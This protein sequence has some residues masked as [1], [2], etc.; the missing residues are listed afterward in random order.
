M[1]VFRGRLKAFQAFLSLTH[2]TSTFVVPCAV[3][4]VIF[5]HLNRSF[6]LTYL[7]NLGVRPHNHAISVVCNYAS[8]KCGVSGSIM[9]SGCSWVDESVCP[10]RTLLTQY[11]EICRIY[12]HQTC[13]LGVLLDKD[14][15]FDVWGLRSSSSRS[16]LV[17]RA[18][19][20]TFGLVDEMSWKLVD[21][22]SPNFGFWCT[23][24]QRRTTLDFEGHGVRVKV[25]ARSDVKKSGLSPYLLNRLNYHSHIEV[26]VKVR[27]RV[28]VR[29]K[30]TVSGVAKGDM[31]ACPPVVAG[32]LRPQTATGAL[33]LDP[34][35][36]AIPRPLLLSPVANSW[37]PP[38]HRRFRVRYFSELLQRTEAS[39][40]TFRHR[41][42]I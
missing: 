4:I 21:G 8:A 27:V 10:S 31:G 41:R 23:W 35:W 37:L 17:Q 20:C 16:R 6:L 26:S 33:P 1:P 24:G 19:K 5:G 11:L 29:V 9:F 39:I 32:K 13:R 25:T 22:S 2:Y 34:G 3:T 18:G 28:R 40:P 7:Q 42:I 14:E 12:F 38:G 30:V 15:R 36:D